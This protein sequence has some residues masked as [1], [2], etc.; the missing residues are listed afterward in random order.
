MSRHSGRERVA[1]WWDA[2]AD[3]NAEK[4]YQAMREMSAHPSATVTLLRAKLKP[5]QKVEATRLDALLAKLDDDSFKA[6]E[7]ASQELVA[8]GDA[9]ES[10]LRAV[11]RGAPNLEVKRRAE[12]ALTQI[13]AGRLRSE[14]AVEVLEMI[15]DA[16]A[17]K[18]LRELASGLRG[19]ARTTDAAG[20]IDRT[21]RP[22]RNDSAGP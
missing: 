15:G 9:V 1:A 14:R 16:A 4:A 3:E 10:R 6:R 12:E 19:A 2:L 18:F 5:I 22:M 17:R 13:D 8:L 20:A 11:L 7:E 21:S